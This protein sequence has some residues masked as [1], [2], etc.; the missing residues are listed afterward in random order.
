MKS[1]IWSLGATISEF[2]FDK[3]V[4]DIHSLSKQFSVDE[5]TSALEFVAS[6]TFERAML[7][8]LINPNF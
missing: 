7:S 2:L 3:S 5:P 4:W 6:A 1:D 8:V